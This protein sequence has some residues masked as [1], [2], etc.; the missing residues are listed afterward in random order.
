MKEH[1]ATRRPPHSP[2]TAALALAAG[3]ALAAGPALAEAG[4]AS[5]TIAYETKGGAVVVMPR[6]AYL[7][8]GA[9]EVSGR[10]IRRVVL[11]VTDVGA[12]L[13]ACKAMDCADGGGIGEGLT[14]DF[15]GGPRLNYWLVANGQRVQY[16]GTADPATLS[17]TTDTPQKLAGRWNLD[18]RAAGAPRIEVEFDAPL[19]RA[20][21]SAR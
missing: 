11:S 18:A 9:D 14:I 2:R 1:T 21:K 17:L 7:V 3:A 13:L 4:A 16:S 8:S 20:M 19:A 5:G 15:D 10:P 12:K 6:H